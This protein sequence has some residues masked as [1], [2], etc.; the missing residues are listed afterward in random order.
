MRAPGSGLRATGPEHLLTACG[1]RLGNRGSRNSYARELTKTRR[2]NPAG[3]SCLH[4]LLP[5]CRRSTA[6]TRSRAQLSRKGRGCP[7]NRRGKK[8]DCEGEQHQSTE[9]IDC[10][11]YGIGHWAIT[12]LTNIGP[13]YKVMKASADDGAFQI[14][15]HG[16][17]SGL[18]D[19]LSMGG[20]VAARVAE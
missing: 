13:G 14:C 17:F 11:A 6:T 15:H 10:D 16:G 2:L 3:F 19:A 9:R 18:N 7:I 12:Q 8:P 4:Q 1:Y 20:S 5:R